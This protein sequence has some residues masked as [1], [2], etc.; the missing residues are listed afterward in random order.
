MSSVSVAVLGAGG[1]VGGHVVHALASRH[2]R[3]TA[4]SLEPPPS[5]AA[6]GVS[7][8][9]LDLD[10]EA[11]DEVEADLAIHLA[12]PS[13]VTEPA[14]V[15]RNVMR[16][17]RVFA[18]RFAR[19]IYISSAVVYGDRDETPRTE[20]SPPAGSGPYAEAKLAV[21]ALAA[22][23]PRCTIVRLANVYGAGMSS[24]NVISDILT[25]L[26][27]PGPLRL[28]DLDPI[29]DFIHAEDVARA[30][31]ELAARPLLGIVNIG[32]GRGTSVAELARMACRAKGTVDR[33][34]VATQPQPRRSYL[35]LDIGRARRE[36]D[37]EPTITLEQGLAGLV[38]EQS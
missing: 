20:E 4:L 21:E 13:I 26:D 14:D 25:Q 35:V 37:W 22:R 17:R 12:E 1:F 24:A 2:H 32:T 30:L 8:R 3:V 27:A 16:A 23:D 6:D 9:Q 19:V 29:R 34:L 36:L 38:Q 10:T 28:R 18:A 31:C 5:V 7:W 11:L 15:Q 33:E